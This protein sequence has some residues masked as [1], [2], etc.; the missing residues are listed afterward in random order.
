MKCIKDRRQAEI[1][2]KRTVTG[3]EIEALSKCKENGFPDW[4]VLAVLKMQKNRKLSHPRQNKL[5]CED[6]IISGVNERKFMEEARRILGHADRK[7]YAVIAFHVKEFGTINEVF[8]FRNG[9]KVLQGIH[10]VFGKNIGKDELSAHAYA[11]RFLL[12]LVY[13]GRTDLKERL[14]RICK[15]LKSTIEFY[16]VHY[17]LMPAFGICECPFGLTMEIE[18]L[19]SRAFMALKAKTF[20]DHPPCAFYEER[21]RISRM[22]LKNMTDRLNPALK[23]RE[24][25]VYYQPKYSASD[26]TL[27]GAEALVRWRTDPDTLVPPGEFIPV[28]ERSGQI[29]ELDRYVFQ[30]VCRDLRRWL[31]EGRGAVPVSVNLSRVHLLDPSVADEYRTEAEKFGVPARLLELEVT[32]SAFA[33]NA[34]ILEESM[35]ELSS[36]GFSLSVDDFGSAYSSL[37]LLCD[38]PAQTIKLDREFINGIEFGERGKAVVSAVIGLA[39]Q[40]RMSVVAEGVETKEQL[41]FLKQARCTAVQ[42]YYFSSPVPERRYAA[43]LPAR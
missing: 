8:G 23:N 37:K 11:D 4:G 10:W 3:D 42:G 7:E 32:E 26:E 13:R 41:E 27:F 14:N 2:G 9:T 5:P 15:D 31:D 40:L 34:P 20:S 24:F 16:G 35:K 1:N 39:G 6:P 19:V 17:E 18:E 28:F 29:A 33:Q 25:V 21:M 30:Q 22:T 12:L 43:L 38:I 36:A